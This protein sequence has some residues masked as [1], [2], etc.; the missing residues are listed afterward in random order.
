[1]PIISGGGGGG[2]GG[3]GFAALASTVLSVDTATFDFQSI[4]GSYSHLRLVICARSDRAA[5][6]ND[7][8][9]MR[10]NNDSATNY[11]SEPIT[12]NNTSLAAAGEAAATG[13]QA[14]YAAAAAATANFFSGADIV[15]FDYANAARVKQFVSTS[16]GASTT[17]V[18][19]QIAF[20]S[21]GIWNSTAAVT[22]VTLYPKN[23]GTVWKAG[24]RADLYGL[25]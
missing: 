7:I 5:A 2:S 8:I 6:G 23:G 9:G 22:R 3:G 1:M 24:S 18:G 16:S 10:F 19:A 4:S 14:G 12:A 21:S 11:S 20:V 17:A 13:F 15:I 25:L